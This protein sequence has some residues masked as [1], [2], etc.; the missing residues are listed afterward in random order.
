MRGIEPELGA[1]HLQCGKHLCFIQALC[2]ADLEL[3]VTE[4]R[5][6]FKEASEGGDVTVK[7]VDAGEFTVLDLADPSDGHPHRLGDLALGQTTPVAHV[8]ESVC[9]NLGDEPGRAA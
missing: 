3:F 7:N 4:V 9:A 5:D 2:S 1:R 8:S 6:D